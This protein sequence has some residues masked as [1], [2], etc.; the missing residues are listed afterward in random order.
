MEKKEVLLDFNCAFARLR[1]VFEFYKSKEKSKDKKRSEIHL[2]SPT[3][4]SPIHLQKSK[5]FRSSSEFNV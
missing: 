4:K 5:F 1:S 2:H 3:T